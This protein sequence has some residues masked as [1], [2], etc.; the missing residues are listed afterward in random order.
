MT[1]RPTGRR[2]DFR[3]HVSG[4]MAYREFVDADGREWRVWS[5]TPSAPRALSSGFEHGWLTFETEDELRR[6]APIPTGWDD[7]SDDGLERLCEA[8]Q[9]ARAHRDA[10]Q[11]AARREPDAD[12]RF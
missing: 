12:A 7:L 6:C 10:S 3:L 4:G 1:P 2:L 11:L 5:T 8:A 9:P